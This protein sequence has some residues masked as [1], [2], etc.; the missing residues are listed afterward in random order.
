MLLN[1]SDG[2]MHEQSAALLA[3]RG[4]AA[5]ALAYFGVENCPTYLVNIPLEYFEHALTWLQAQE[6]IDSNCLGVIG[7]SRGGELALLLGATFPALKAVVAGA[8]SGLVHSGMKNSRAVA[9]SAWSYQ[10]KAVPY[11]SVK[12]S[13]EAMTSFFLNG[14][15]LKPLR[16]LG[17]FL[18]E[19]EEA[20]KGSEMAER[21]TIPVEKINGPLLLISGQDDQLWPSAQ[22]CELIIKRLR[23]HN[24]PYLYS[25]LS[26][27]EAGH[28]VCFPY[29]LPS[30]PPW[31]ER[32]RNLHIHFGGTPKAN[33][34]AT[35]D[36]WGKILQFLEKYLR[37]IT[38]S[39]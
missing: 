32:S 22:Y 10:G 34:H 4:Y 28:F 21:A 16:L 36:S 39:I 35:S 31:I 29:G 2:G 11:I 1:G 18:P 12:Y 14:K 20:A 3:S 37:S 26:Y 19:L 7:F 5:L 25:H 9:E 30:L 8:P 6:S 27:Q 38:L 17:S 23:Q 24:Y 33:A 15:Q 13:P